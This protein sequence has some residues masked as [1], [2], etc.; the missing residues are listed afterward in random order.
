[1]RKW[2]E[3]EYL[4]LHRKMG[5]LSEIMFV[6][7]FCCPNIKDRVLLHFLI[8]F[9]IISILVPTYGSLFHCKLWNSRN[10]HLFIYLKILPRMH[11]KL[12]LC[13]TGGRGGRPDWVK[14]SGSQKGRQ[15]SVQTLTS[16]PDSKWA[17]AKPRLKAEVPVPHAEASI[18][19][20][21]L[22]KG[23]L[24]HCW[25]WLSGQ[26]HPCLKGAKSPPSRCVSELLYH[27]HG[28][29][30]ILQLPSPLECY[31]FLWSVATET[32]L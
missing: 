9:C 11:P 19:N 8:V 25:I 13:N 27:G 5:R 26:E 24:R 14:V 17:G 2:N 29:Y 1:M 3:S 15:R 10:F 12:V 4:L 32:I 6:N 20:W 7:T 31:F 21:W 30:F 23:Y 16:I 18:T 22:L 28:P